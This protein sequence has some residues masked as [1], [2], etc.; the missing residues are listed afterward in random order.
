MVKVFALFRGSEQ[1]G[2]QIWKS[3]EMAIKEMNFSNNQ[4][5]EYNDFIKKNYPER[6]PIKLVEVKEVSF[7]RKKN[8]EL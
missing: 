8:L 4:F 2:R 7:N 3:K 1:V 5:K 6:E